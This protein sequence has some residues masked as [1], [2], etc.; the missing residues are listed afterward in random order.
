M[1]NQVMRQVPAGVHEP[2]KADSSIRTQP[3]IDD[4][5]SQ[6]R[7]DKFP[8]AKSSPDVCPHCARNE[9]GIEA[10]SGGVGN[11]RHDG[12]EKDFPPKLAQSSPSVQRKLR[13]S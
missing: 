9:D 12:D 1:S 11:K 8:Y 13:L 3:E 5:Q 7:I 10:S 4:W 2:R 6:N